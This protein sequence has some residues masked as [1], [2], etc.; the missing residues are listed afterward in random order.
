MKSAENFVEAI[1]QGVSPVEALHFLPYYEPRCIDRIP[2]E[3]Y[4]TTLRKGWRFFPVHL[5]NHFAEERAN[6]LGATENLRQLSRWARQ[7]ANWALATGPESGVSVLEVDGDKGL[8]SLLNRCG[9]DWSWLDTLRFMAGEKRFIFFAWPASRRQNCSDQQIDEGLRVLGEGDWLLVP[10]S[11][12]PHGVLHTYLNPQDAVGAAL[13]WLL[14]RVFESANSVDP[15]R[16]FP[17]HSAG[18]NVWSNAVAA[19]AVHD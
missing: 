8:N 17:P 1:K 13:S 14:D 15:W 18:R 7:R 9:D 6:L 4:R 12:E 19:E 5:N 11:C 3:V 16:P 10:P 2:V